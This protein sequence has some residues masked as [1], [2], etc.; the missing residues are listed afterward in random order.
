MTPAFTP[1]AVFG[2]TDS[3]IRMGNEVSF[4]PAV[5][6]LGGQHN[7]GVVGGFML[8]DVAERRAAED[9]AVIVEDEVAV[10]AGATILEGAW[11]GSALSSARGTGNPRWA[12]PMIVAGV[13]ARVP[14]ARVTRAQ[15][16]AHEFALYGQAPSRVS[17]GRHDQGLCAE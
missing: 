4:G 16:L 8:F 14:R 1:G 5:R 6:V 3:E 2:A 11:I 10:G 13:P 15:V 7:S 17:G 9:I 12:A